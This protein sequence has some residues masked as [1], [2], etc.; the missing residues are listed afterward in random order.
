MI[1]FP[2]WFTLLI[3]IVNAFLVYRIRIDM[4]EKEQDG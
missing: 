4:G 3:L 2:Y 1:L